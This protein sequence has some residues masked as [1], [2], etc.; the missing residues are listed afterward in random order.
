[1]LG[2]AALAETLTIATVNNGDMIRMQALTDDFTAKHPDIELNWVT[3]EENILRERVTTDIATQGGQYD[4]MTIGTYEVPIWAKQGWLLPLDSLG[5]D[6]DVA[7]IIPAI[8]GGLSYEGKLYAAPFYGE[9]SFVMYRTDLMEKAGLEMPDAPTW[10]FIADAARKMTDRENG[11]NGIC[12]RGK[13]GWGEN[14]AFLTALSNSFGARWFDMDWQPQFD[15]PAWKNTLQSYVDLMNEAGPTGASSN[16]FNENLALF[17]QGKCG[18]W[19]DATVAASFVS[20]PTDSTVADKV[21]YALAPDTGLG[22]RGNWLWAWS[23]AVP[24]G[25]K[26][27][28]A[29]QTFVSW[30]TSKAYLELVASKEGWANV[31]PGTRTSLYENPEYAKVPFAK[32]T[33][34]SINAADPTN[35]TV[36]EVPYVGV[37]F[38]AIPEF[39]GLGTTVGQLFSA[40]LAGQMS[41]DDALAQAQSVATRE[42]TRAGYI[43]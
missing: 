28:D 8:A 20:N 11:I 19:I 23:L 34:D 31:P 3:L 9:S 1:M 42:M 10:D 26:N 16:G 40:A 21:S 15:Q 29:A 17:Q 30:A 18:M 12:L 7:D 39:Q 33:L 37:Q 27:A 38:V 13:A 35:P 32:M 4:V 24:A 2:T 14:M 6:Y 36:D 25:T 43:K 22:K 5:D 41:V